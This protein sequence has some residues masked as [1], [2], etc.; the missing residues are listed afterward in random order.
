MHAHLVVHPRPPFPH[1]VGAWK[2]IYLHIFVCCVCFLHIGEIFL[3]FSPWMESYFGNSQR[4]V[5]SF[6]I[7]CHFPHCACP[8][9]PFW[10]CGVNGQQRITI[11]GFVVVDLAHAMLRFIVKFELLNLGYFS[12]IL[13]NQFWLQNVFPPPIILYLA[14]CASF[15]L[16]WIGLE[17]IWVWTSLI[18]LV[19]EGT[20]QTEL[21]GWI[22][23]LHTLNSTRREGIAWGTL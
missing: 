1:A 14:V 11:L 9:N 21:G 13:L 17:W 16:V 2:A 22:S 4:W 10:C 19:R 23:S 15:S 12:S 18:N 20:S 8:G 7:W 5:L 3:H 6:T